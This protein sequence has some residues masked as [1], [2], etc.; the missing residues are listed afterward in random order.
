MHLS[1]QNIQTT[2]TLLI[3]AARDTEPSAA[4]QG[5]AC[6]GDGIQVILSDAKFIAPLPCLMC[7][8]C[9]TYFFLPNGTARLRSSET[10]CFLHHG[11]PSSPTPA[12]KTQKTWTVACSHPHDGENPE[13]R[14]ALFLPVFQLTAESCSGI[15][16][17]LLEPHF[18]ALCRQGF[19][20]DALTD[21]E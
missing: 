18:S 14:S 12:A 11:P 10:Q 19:F 20:A 1:T 4:G 2:K 8:F 21:T 6:H 17:V 15:F 3:V 7:I 9:H 16:P 13:L 5:C